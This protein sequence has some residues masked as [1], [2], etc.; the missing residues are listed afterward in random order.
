MA[1]AI[2]AFRSGFRVTFALSVF[3]LI[4]SAVCTP[5]SA[6]AQ[7]APIVTAPATEDPAVALAAARDALDTDNLVRA[8][9]L[10]TPLVNSDRPPVV[11][12][13]HFFLGD[14]AEKELHFANAL[15]SYRDSV[16]VDPGGRYASRALA[17][18]EFLSTR[19]EGDFAP[20][21]ALERVRANPARSSE[22]RA[23][24]DLV[25]RAAGFPPGLS[26]VEARLLA[27]QAYAGRLNRPA[28]AV[29][30]L[31]ALI[32][33]SSA[34]ADLHRLALDLLAQTRVRLGQFS[35]ALDE[36]RA[37]GGRDETVAQMRQLAR[38]EKLRIAAL[39]VTLC[40]LLAGLIAVVRAVRKQQ[41]GALARAWRRPLP[42]AHIAMFSI[43]GAM[44][45]HT[46]DDHDPNPFLGLGAGAILVYLA[47]TAWSFVGS[48]RAPARIVRVT[49]CSLAM[50]AVSFL[51][52][53]RFDAG[54][55]EGIGL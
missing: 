34:S 25:R 30:V 44:L 6:R 55:L 38:R 19:S 46:Y 7:T 31:L 2:N 5:S 47:A 48:Q 41:F 35:I 26:R 3:A 40:V 11:A 53:H 50:L 13:A 9:E 33:D 36:Q 22:G 37:L 21:V 45:A 51:A 28:D 52:M 12:Q 10:L 24:D 39:A 14:L 8:R 32:A 54:M 49:L 17:R 1:R 4:G 23:I 16:G 29:P 27:A 15:T 42:L 20:L 18:I 43:G